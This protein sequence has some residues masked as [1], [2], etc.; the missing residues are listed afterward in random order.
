MKSV[1]FKGYPEPTLTENAIVV[2]QDRYLAK[3]ESGKLV[4]TPKGMLV[5]V[6]KAV[7]RVEEPFG[8]VEAV[9]R[10]S[11]AFYDIMSKGEFLPNSPCLMN[12]GRTEDGAY[13]ACF[14]LPLE[15]SIEGIFDT[16]K[17]TALVQKAGGGTG[18]SFDRLR[19]TGAYIRSSGG[20]TSGPISFW[21]VL[22]EATNAIQ[23]GAFRRGANMGM[24]TVTHPDILKFLTAKQD[25]SL[26][27]NYNI[28]IKIPDAW[29]EGYIKSPQSLHV[30]SHSS[31]NRKYLIPKSI[32]GAKIKDYTLLDLVE[33]KDL[34][35]IPG[36]HNSYWT[37]KD[38]FDIILKCAWTTGEPGLFF[39]DRANQH[40]PTP[41]VGTYEAT[42]PCGEQVLL[43]YESCNLGSI[44]VACCVKED[45]TFDW[46]KL[47]ELTRVGTRFLDDVVDASPYPIPEITEM[48]HN[49]RKIG[50]GLMGF[51]DALFMLGLAYD[52][53][54]G[55]SFGR[56]LMM[57]I[58]EVSLECSE[59][60][61]TE[62]GN[63]PNW[64]GSRWEL[65]W[66]NRPMRNS[67][68]TTVAP[69]GT[70][71]I[72][73]DCS[74]GLEPLYNLTFFRNV[75]NGKRLVEVNKVFE[76]VAK[77]RGFYSPELMTKVLAEGTLA[78]IQGIPEDVKKLFVTAQD[79]SPEWHVRM[80]AAFQENCGSSISK[81]INMPNSA[82][83]EEVEQTYILAY[84]LGCKGVT[85]YRDGCRT[86]Q[87]MALSTSQDKHDGKV[88]E[89]PVEKVY[90]DRKP[91]KTPSIL[92]SIRLRQNT[93]HGNM[94]VNISMDPRTGREFEV[95]AQLG[96]AGDVMSSDLEAICRLASLYLRLGGSLHDIQEQLLGIG[97]NVSVPTKNG[98]VSS[99][100]DGLGHSIKNYLTAREDNGLENLLLGKYII[101]ET[102]KK[103]ATAPIVTVPVQVKEEHHP[104]AKGSGKCPSCGS[105]LIRSEGCSTCSQGCGYSKCG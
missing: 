78:N 35:K 45:G 16:V 74:G 76:K 55:V 20:T 50:L 23:Q 27:T 3:D 30:V 83:I 25:L 47:R 32:T 77:E 95:F 86:N 9:N 12:A 58:N 1:D 104:V 15:D 96:K 92:S 65:E 14:V 36:D 99:L 34:A 11:R 66:G 54:A 19:P 73:A 56:D 103:A 67:V 13:S 71:S 98:K 82:K 59:E 46:P 51:A 38:V 31:N 52:S 68:V 28:S 7:A 105:M 17:N 80:Q 88:V 62:K 87:P 85:V 90:H 41:Q 24:M 93:P 101:Q 84:Q 79:I 69:T 100:A 97:S 21:K 94:H 89:V 53:E 26:F 81:T 49:N 91:A 33:V 8:G 10:W 63:F 4:E 72:L 64:K 43:P 75:L 44:N 22:S 18:F 102:T 70:I 60:L 57:F 2:L 29:M 5:R 42:N 37:Q 48:C 61:A 40:N 6:A 39:I